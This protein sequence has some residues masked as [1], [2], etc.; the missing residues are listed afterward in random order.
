[1]FG[2]GKTTFTGEQ[3]R[4]FVLDSADVSEEDGTTTETDTSDSDDNFNE[5]KSS[6]GDSSEVESPMQ[7]TDEALVDSVNE[8]LIEER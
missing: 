6:E 3:V 7:R 5:K 2:R 4:E 1:M 8:L